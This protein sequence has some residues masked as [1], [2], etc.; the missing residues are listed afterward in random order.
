MLT[1]KG[2]RF[3]IMALLHLPPGFKARD[4]AGINPIQQS[5]GHVPIGATG[6]P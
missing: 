2:F 1:H 5:A 3:S 4:Q 6:A